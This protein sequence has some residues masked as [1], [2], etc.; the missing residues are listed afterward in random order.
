MY[1]EGRMTLAEAD[2]LPMKETM[3]SYRQEAA[4]EREREASGGRPPRVKEGE[5]DG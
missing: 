4:Q 2:T 5:Q 1:T 3:M